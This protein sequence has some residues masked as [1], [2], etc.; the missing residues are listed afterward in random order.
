MRLNLKSLSVVRT[1]VTATRV[2]PLKG[3]IL[4]VEKARFDKM[5]EHGEIKALI[6]A[7][8]TG[9]GKEDFDVVDVITRQTIIQYRP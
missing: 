8:G 3:K 9:I 1:D 5:L 7:L 4:N 6:T 2:L